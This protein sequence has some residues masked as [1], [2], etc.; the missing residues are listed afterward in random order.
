MWE[1]CHFL[2][3]HQ[4]RF[5]WLDMDASDTEGINK[6]LCARATITGKSKT[7]VGYIMRLDVS[8]AIGK[9]IRYI[10]QRC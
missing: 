3:W 10:S 1:M 4:S 5:Y 9:A 8:V 2:K 7:Y 6:I